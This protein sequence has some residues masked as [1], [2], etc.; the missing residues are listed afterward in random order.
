MAFPTTYTGW[1][2]YIRDWI[3]ADEYSE[4]QVA[5]FLDLAQ[6]RLNR[7]MY[8]YGMEA[9]ATITIVDANPINLLVAVP[10]FKKV[11]LVSVQG[12]GPAN[13]E[14]IDKIQALLQQAVAVGST[15]IHACKYCIDAGLLY[16]Y[17]VI[18]T[19]IIDFFYYKD[20]PEL[21]GGT[22]PVNSNV[23]SVQYPDALLY[24]TLLAAAP[25]MKE[26]EDVDVWS[27]N[28]LAALSTANDESNKIKRGSTPLLREV[29]S[30]G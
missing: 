11:R 28:Y 21:I 19:G 23:F 30:Y 6:V 18:S 15:D 4:A 8:S 13:V 22:S 3:G 14:A 2:A 16:L 7:E 17:P 27:N 9:K 29:R 10:D 12:W 24:A 20:I 26:N 25:Y 5:S 1:I